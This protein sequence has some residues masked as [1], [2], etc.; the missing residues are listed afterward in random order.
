MIENKNLNQSIIKAFT[1]LDAFTDDKK[2]WG[3]RELANKTGYNKSTTYRLLS[4]LVYLNVIHQNENEK[5][6]LGSKLFE[7]G[8]RVSLYKSLITATNQ[9]IKNVALEIQ[10]TV[11]LS[12]LK[13]HQV[14]YIN[15]ADSLQGLKISTSI[16]SYQPI[17][18]TASGKLLLAFSSIDKQ[19]KYFK[20]NNFTKFTKKTIT[21]ISDL[22]TELHII[23]K[24]GYALDLEELELGLICI[25][26]PI[27]NKKGNT[28]ASISASSLQ[29]VLKSKTYKTTF[30]SYKKAH[31]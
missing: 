11:L 13:E 22:K 21:K 18:A 14:F 27:Y 25:A 2:E 5:Y 30:Q 20:N 1:V 23:K 15:K 19:E 10:E 24:Q 6:C 28:I 9:P 31:P 7:L 26:I 17:H 16:G 12:I 4:T 29:V 3:V 8:N